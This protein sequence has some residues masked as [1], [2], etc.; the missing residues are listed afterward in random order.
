MRKFLLPLCLTMV[1]HAAAQDRYVVQVGAYE[2]E[3]PELL[4]TLE[5]YGE[6]VTVRVA[7]D[8]VR[9]A[10]GYYPTVADAQ[11]TLLSLQDAGFPDAFV[12]ERQ[13]QF[14]ALNV[15]NDVVETAPLT[16]YS[17][18]AQMSANEKLDSLSKEER[19]NVVLLDGRLHI[20]NGNEFIP[21][22]Q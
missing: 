9:V 20:K 14:A 5:S 13:G 15:S 12:R 22:A 16:V 3:R 4:Q 21:L 11:E 2:H 17:R 10:V 8:L 18:N 1:S 7:D 6:P 19:D